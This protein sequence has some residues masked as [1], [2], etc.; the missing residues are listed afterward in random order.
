MG[1]QKN[2]NKDYHAL[3]LGALGLIYWID[4]DLIAL[5]QTARSLSEITRDHPLPPV[6]SFTFYYFGTLEYHRNEL[7]HAEKKLTEAVKLHYAYSPMNFAHGAFALALT[8][9]ALGRPDP[10]RETCDS[11]IHDAIETNNT[12]M[13]KVARAFEAELALRQGRLSLATQWLE[14]YNAHPFVPPF[15]FYMP[16]LTAVKI[17]LAQHTTESRLRAD[18]LLSQ[19]TAYLESIHNRRFQIDVLA[20]QALLHD[21]QGEDSAALEKLSQALVLAEPGGLVRPFV[22]LGP[23]MAALLKRLINGNVA[24]HY[25]GCILAAFKEEAHRTAPG[26]SDHD[27]SPNH[28]IPPA[29]DHTVSQPLLEPLTT[30]ELEILKLLALRLSNKEIA[31]QEFIAVTTVKKHLTNIFGKLTVA[32]RRQA[33]EKAR[34]LNII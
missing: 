5:E 19:L 34:A 20:L 17:L 3:Y 18:D 30:R 8:L 25:A 22:D 33:V 23:Q 9:Q 28:S 12:D 16:Q 26:P 6:D 7:E 27:F 10:A 4:A 15:R 13:L 32:N 31:T 24:V 11:V 2:R 1:R 14:K 29:S 21:T